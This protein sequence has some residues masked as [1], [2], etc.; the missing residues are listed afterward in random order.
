MEICRIEGCGNKRGLAKGLCSTHYHRL[1]KTGSTDPVPRVNAR[2]ACSMD[3][4]ETIT[5]AKGFCDKHYRRL[6]DH[7]DPY[8]DV[9]VGGQRREYVSYTGAHVRVKA[10]RGAASDYECCLC[11]DDAQQWAYDHEDPDELH[12]ARAGRGVGRTYSAKSEHYMPMCAPCH[13][14][15]DLERRGVPE[16][17]RRRGRRAANTGEGVADS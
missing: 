3:G 12:D 10:D 13:A 11:G 16:G 9:G 7:G 8:R 4:C 5:T 15:Y 6:L 14:A 2:G 17:W 1:R